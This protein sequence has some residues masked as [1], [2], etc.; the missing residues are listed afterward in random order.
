M[1][2]LRTFKEPVLPEDFSKARLM[3]SMSR[4]DAR[5]LVFGYRE[6]MKRQIEQAG[7]P[8]TE[9]GRLLR[10]TIFLDENT[11]HLRTLKQIA[12]LDEDASV[13]PLAV[14][15]EIVLADGK[16][17]APNRV[18]HDRATLD[19]MVGLSLEFLQDNG[20]FS[21]DPSQFYIKS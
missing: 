1:T 9:Q 12:G 5:W 19:G 18:A 15:H 13:D 6:F 2:E 10:E 16:A 14:M 11:H 3:G 4:I 20:P 21:Y 7:G 17:D 8:N